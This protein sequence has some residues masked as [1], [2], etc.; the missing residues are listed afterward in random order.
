MSY[1]LINTNDNTKKMIITVIIRLLNMTF[2]NDN[3]CNNPTY[4]H[5]KFESERGPFEN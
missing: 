2:K 3:K 1:D 4:K 5:D